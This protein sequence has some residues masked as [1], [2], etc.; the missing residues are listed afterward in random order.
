M[1]ARVKGKTENTLLKMPFKAAYM[2]R[3]G[4]IQPI[5]GVRSKTGWVQTA[6]SVIAPLYPALN[7]LLPNSTTTSSNLGR[8]LIQVA[9]TGYDRQ[10]LSSADFNRLSDMK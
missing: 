2:F 1:W 7:R 9:V 4:Y 3:P 6:Y 5:G 10:V 8:A